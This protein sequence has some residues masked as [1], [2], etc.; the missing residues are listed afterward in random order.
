MTMSQG[1]RSAAILTISALM[2]AG[3]AGCGS[4]PDDFQSFLAWNPFSQSGTP[5]PTDKPTKRLSAGE[6]KRLEAQA[7][8]DLAARPIG[9]VTEWT[10]QDIDM[11]SGTPVTN[12][13]ANG[14]KSGGGL[15]E[16]ASQAD[17]TLIGD[18][19]DKPE[20]VRKPGSVWITEMDISHAH[21]KG[22]GTLWNGMISAPRLVSVGGKLGAHFQ[23]T[24]TDNKAAGIRNAWTAKTIDIDYYPHVPGHPMNTQGMTVDT[25]D[26]YAL[27]HFTGDGVDIWFLSAAER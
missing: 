9:N 19:A 18:T 3:L 21:A 27:S 10:H 16:D 8:K 14:Y 7:W 2:L 4:M 26:S 11:I 22:M 23:Y 5:T 6:R 13:A 25:V 20:D 17:I 12:A 24:L 15:H 1:K